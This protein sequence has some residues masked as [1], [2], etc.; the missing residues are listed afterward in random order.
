M[1]KMG[2]SDLRRKKYRRLEPVQIMDRADY[3]KADV[4]TRV[5]LIQGLIPLGLMHVQETLQAEVQQLAGER[6]ARKGD[7]AVGSRYGTNPG[8]VRLGGQRLGLRVPR[9]RGEQGEIPLHSY[10]QLHTGGGAV[11]EVLLRRVLHGISCRNYEGAAAA[12]PGAM[13]LSRS[14]VSRSFVQA[15]AAQLKAFQERELSGEKYVAIF[16]DGKS[17]G[18]SMMVIA[19]GITLAGE[20]RVL[21]FVETDTENAR[22]L[23]TFLRSLL[24]RGLDLSRGVLVV[25][26]GGKGL[27][28]A[29][30]KVLAKRAVVQRCMWHKREN[31]VGYLPQREQAAWRRQLQRAMDRPTYKEAK[32]ALDALA[33]ELEMINQ[34]A[35]A[36]L[37]EGLA[38]V[39]TLHRLGLYAKLGRSFKTTNCLENVNRMIEDRCR[40]VDCWKNSN[41]RQRWLAAALLDIEP[42]LRTVCGFRHLA[43][44]REAVQ[45]ELNIETVNQH[46]AQAG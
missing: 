29:V 37:R 38:E 27:R 34:S 20:K 19:L 11:D 26:D 44:L 1:R 13:G 22:V 8:S 6:H 12:I 3:A 4:D 18:E 40:K 16:L 5:E 42:R 46:L 21:G 33:E 36:S 15:S 28:A 7:Q 9:V 17:F 30:R 10:Q 39:L 43:A 23:S 14:T 31:V 35:A 25:L 45:R 2:T 24:A 41:Q 32:S